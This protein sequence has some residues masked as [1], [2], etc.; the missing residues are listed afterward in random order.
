LDDDVR[1]AR[2]FSIL[3]VIGQHT[4]RHDVCSQHD[5]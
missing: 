2:V 3:G 5:M 4:V 1:V